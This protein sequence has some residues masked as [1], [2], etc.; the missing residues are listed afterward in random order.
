MELPEHLKPT[1][2]TPEKA[3]ELLARFKE[4]TKP[5][6]PRIVTAQRPFHE[7]YQYKPHN[8]AQEMARR[9][10]QMERVAKSRA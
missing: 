9:R 4:M 5:S 2:L 7:S 8:G 1:N 6:T 10:K 3:R